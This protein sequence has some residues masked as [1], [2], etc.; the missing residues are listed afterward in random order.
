MN[1]KE[2]IDTLKNFNQ[3]LDVKVLVDYDGERMVDDAENVYVD[4]D[5]NGCRIL[6]IN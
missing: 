3:D 5:R 4:L 6:I 1:V 2:L